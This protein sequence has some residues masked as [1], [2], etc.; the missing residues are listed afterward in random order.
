MSAPE[1]GRPDNAACYTYTPQQE[2]T[3]HLAS[4]TGDFGKSNSSVSAGGRDQS[5]LV[6]R[7]H[8]HGLLVHAYTFR[9]EVRL[10]G[11]YMTHDA[12][13]GPTLSMDSRFSS[14]WISSL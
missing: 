3:G 13:L 10:L 2:C 4:G 1:C 11:S 5:S 6:Q 7:A 12:S 8:Q 14:A 9:N